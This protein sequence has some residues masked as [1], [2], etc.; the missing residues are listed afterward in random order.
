MSARN[1]PQVLPER[2]AASNEWNHPDSESGDFTAKLFCNAEF[3]FE[4]L[5][6]LIEGQPEFAFDFR[7]QFL[8][9]A[10]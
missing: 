5:P 2:P 10:A 4:H 3:W 8:T 9:L 6:R 7:A 1:A